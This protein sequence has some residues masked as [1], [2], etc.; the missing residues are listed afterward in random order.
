MSVF[1]PDR[2]DI[3]YNF[4]VGEDGKAYEGRGWGVEGEHADGFNRNS[5]G[6]IPSGNERY[7]LYNM[8]VVMMHLTT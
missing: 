7:K 4:L 2:M 1:L 8:Q 6:E 5:I 3:G